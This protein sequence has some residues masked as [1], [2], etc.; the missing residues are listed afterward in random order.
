MN[1][2]LPKVKISPELRLPIKC[3]KGSEAE[4]FALAEKLTDDL[5]QNI[6]D[7][8][9]KDNTAVSKEVIEEKIQDILPVPL[10][11]KIRELTALKS[12]EHC[13]LGTMYI[14]SQDNDNNEF[15][16]NEAGVEM[17][18][19]EDGRVY[20]DNIWILMH[21]FRHVMD[22]ILCPKIIMKS[23]AANRANL[24][25]NA[26]TVF[27]AKVL[28]SDNKFNIK[29]RISCY[30]K[31]KKLLQ[32]QSQDAKID[33]L[34]HIRNLIKSEINAYSHMLEYQFI[35]NDNVGAEQNL[36]TDKQRLSE[37]DFEHKLKFFNRILYRKIRNVRKNNS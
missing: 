16:V 33:I 8:Y 15:L 6:K 1:V 14:S 25:N 12:K 30:L 4:C 23:H 37:L 24:A 13:C 27:N 35:I 29:N 11:I 9:T 7:L 28:Q 34:Q 2:R 31:L 5:F 18:L 32:N 19:T 17:P 36:K 21:E 3:T 10:N 20:Y 26:F 22:Y